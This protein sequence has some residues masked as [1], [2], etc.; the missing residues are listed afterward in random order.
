MAAKHRTAGNYHN[1]HRK[2]EIPIEV[3][4]NHD[5]AV[6]NEFAIQPEPG[7]SS[8]SRSDT[9]SDTSINLQINTLLTQESEE[10]AEESPV[11]EESWS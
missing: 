11:H 3:Q 4:L 6:F 9:E 1:L 7:Q 10:S 8:K 5:S 2:V